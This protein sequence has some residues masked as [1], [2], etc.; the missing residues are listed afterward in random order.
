MAHVSIKE[1]KELVGFA[2]FTVK[3][4]GTSM[5]D[6]KIGFEDAW[7]MIELLQKAQPAFAGVAEVPAEIADLD[8]AEVDELKK[9]ILSEFDIPNDQLESVIKDA[10]MIGLALARLY[11]KVKKL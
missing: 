11:G 9:Y 2:L 5:S 8:S 6:G 1:T 3:A 10:L 7:R 4:V